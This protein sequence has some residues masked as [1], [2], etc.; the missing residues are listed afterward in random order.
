MQ[1]QYFYFAKNNIRFIL[2]ITQYM[3]RVCA[4]DV[5]TN[6]NI[7][8]VY[9]TPVFIS[10]QIL[11]IHKNIRYCIQPPIHIVKALCCVYIGLL[12]LDVWAESLM[13][14]SQWLG[15]PLTH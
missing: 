13:D 3:L 2:R 9:Y 1:T 7:V 15:S 5:Y 6:N 12:Y 8:T 14:Q 11:C 4:V 10:F